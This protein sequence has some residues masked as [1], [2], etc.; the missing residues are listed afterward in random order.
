MGLKN[1]CSRTCVF[2]AAFHCPATALMPIPTPLHIFFM[3]CLGRFVC[4]VAFDVVVRFVTSLRAACGLN[5]CVCGVRWGLWRMR[6]K[7]V[8]IGMVII[9]EYARLL[10]GGWRVAPKVV[11]IALVI[12]GD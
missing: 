2:H 4:F 11:T 12:F 9:C 1:D 7:L 8:I 3:L 10:A 6:L 5:G